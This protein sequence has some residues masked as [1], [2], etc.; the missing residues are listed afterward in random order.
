ML[1]YPDYLQYFWQPFPG[2]RSTKCYV[3]CSFVQRKQ[4]LYSETEIFPGIEI[5]INFSMALQWV[6]ASIAA[7][8]CRHE[9]AFCGC[10]SISCVCVCV[11]ARAYTHTYA[12]LCFLIGV[13]H[14]HNKVSFYTF[15]HLA[16]IKHLLNRW[17]FL[18][19]F[20]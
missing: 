19:E 17:L 10:F 1:S 14:T 13:Q 8:W 7:F 4:I 18:L 11:H 15:V 2:K 6:V 9:E 5:S 3:I 20:L 16:S 12:R